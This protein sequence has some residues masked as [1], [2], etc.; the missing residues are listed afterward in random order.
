MKKYRIFYLILISTLLLFQACEDF[1]DKAPDED[2]NIKEVFANEQLTGRFLASVYYN[3]PWEMNFAN[4]WGQNP[5]V[6]AADEMDE[7]YTD[8]FCNWMNMGA[9]SPDNVM[10]DIWD[11]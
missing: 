11:M 9:W 2:L 10:Q 6:G 4:N 7:P 1:L 3:L 5:F 8:V